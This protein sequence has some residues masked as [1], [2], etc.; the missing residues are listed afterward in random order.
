[1]KRKKIVFVC[2]GNTCRS[3]MAEYLLKTEIKRRKIKWWDVTSRGLKAEIGGG[4]S[5]NS[6]LALA[7]LNITVDKFRPRQ[8]TQKIID[9]ATLVVT[10]TE[11]QRRILGD[12]GNVRSIKE[13]CGYDVPDPYGC[14][15]EVYRI[16]RD[17][18][19]DACTNIIENYILKFEE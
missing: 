15:I 2:T 11:E 6:K 19:K 18:I 17:A 14:G 12:C 1:M 16:T 4:M 10:M 9:E 8:L 5:L 13:M 3:P 7:D